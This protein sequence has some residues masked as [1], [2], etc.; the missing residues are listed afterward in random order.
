MMILTDVR[1]EA[2]PAASHA[3]TDWSY[4]LEAATQSIRTMPDSR[5]Y[6]SRLESLS[7]TRWPNILNAR[8]RGGVEKNDKMLGRV[9]VG[10]PQSTGC[11]RS[12]RLR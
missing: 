5:F 3:K 1:L 8:G 9:G 7:V 11:W 10:G 4:R 2:D 12:G 6:A